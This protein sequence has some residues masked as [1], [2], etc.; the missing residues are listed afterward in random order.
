VHPGAVGTRLQRYNPRAG[1]GPAIPGIAMRLVFPGGEHAPVE[2]A[3]GTT[4]V[5]SDAACGVVLSGPG[6]SPRHCEIT[7]AGDHAVVRA[8]DPAATTVVNGRQIG[9]EADLNPGDLLLFGRIGCSVNASERTQAQQA[10]A[11]RRPPPAAAE[12]DG[13][14]RVRATLPRFLLRGVSGATLGKT[15]AVADTAVIGRQPDCDIPVAAEEISRHHARVRPSAD[16]LLV[17]DLGSANGTFINGKRVQTGLLKPGEELRLDTVRFL[18]VA[19]GMD[20][21]QQSAPARAD[22]AAPSGRGGSNPLWIAIG[23]I[24]LAALVFLGLKFAGMV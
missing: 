20:A 2:L 15:F 8:L 16:G 14:T 9:A 3:E 12:A 7:L 18:L 23:V 24:V 6:V 11:M 10:S 13:R 5:G 19:P 1:A 17:E 21:R 4:S 22:A